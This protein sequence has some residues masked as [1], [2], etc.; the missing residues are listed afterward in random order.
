MSNPVHE[1]P[2]NPG[3]MT[4]VPPEG[5]D[6]MPRGDKTGPPKGSRGPRSGQGKG[7]GRN[8]SDKGAGKQ[9]GGKRNVK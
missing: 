5:G 2:A 1:C 3:V 9:T 8:T 7:Q 6:F 4:Y